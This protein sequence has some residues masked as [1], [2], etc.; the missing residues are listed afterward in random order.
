[1]ENGIYNPKIA[2]SLPDTHT[3]FVVLVKMFSSGW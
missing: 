3:D 2:F 1:M